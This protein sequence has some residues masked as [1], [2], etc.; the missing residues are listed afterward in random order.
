MSMWNSLNAMSFG[1]RGARYQFAVGLGL[2]S[3][4]PLLGLW[5]LFSVSQGGHNLVVGLSGLLV[6]LTMLVA[7]ISGFV[8]LRQYPRSII[9]LRRYTEEIIAG[10]LPE[11]VEM[12]RG[13]DDIESIERGMNIIVDSL[14]NRLATAER[15]KHTLER[16]LLEADKMKSLGLM[17]SGI[18]HD[19]GNIM[20]VVTGSS[21]L[22]QK[23]LHDPAQTQEFLRSITEAGQQA[24]EGR[25]SRQRDGASK[26]QRRT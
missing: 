3:V 19:F 2:V 23:T 11:K 25:H 21:Q 5:Y 8:V 7:S 20:C 16:Q 18:A 1:K 14:R 22:A 9:K 17:A 6:A 12:P 4:F 10:H 26:G 13:E 24:A 15:E